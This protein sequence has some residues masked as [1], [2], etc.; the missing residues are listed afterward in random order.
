MR[1]T[2]FNGS[3]RVKK[4]NSDVLLGHLRAGFEEGG[5]GGWEQHYLAQTR[6]LDEQLAAYGN[7]ECVLVVFPLYV[8]A[9]PSQVMGFF[10]ALADR[11]GRDDNPP[12]LFLVHSGFPE[13]CHSRSVERYLEKL[14]RRLGS[15]YLGT[16]VKGGS[17]GIQVMPPMMTRKLYRTMGELGRGF[18]ERGALDPALVKTLAGREHYQGFSMVLIRLLKAIGLTDQHWNQQLKKN[19]VWERRFDR[20]Y[21]P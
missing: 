14:T 16:M 4:S 5:G 1:L 13:A 9:M 20:P 11:V 19:G 10:Q 3:P 8:D 15:E 6:K 7:A 21:A 12:M 2:V 18:G 17:E